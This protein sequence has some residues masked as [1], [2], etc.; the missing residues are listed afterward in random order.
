SLAATV[1]GFGFSLGPE[2]LPPKG[3]VICAHSILA[4]MAK[5]NSGSGV[6]QA[7]SGG[8]PSQ[9]VATAYNR[10]T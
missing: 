8:Q 4:S 10:S 1:E 7:V 9:P 3:L 2:D 6:R 5:N